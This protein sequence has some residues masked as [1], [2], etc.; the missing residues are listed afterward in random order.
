MNENEISAVVQNMLELMEPASLSPEQTSNVPKV[1]PTSMKRNKVRIEVELEKEDNL[2]NLTS[3]SI[4]PETGYVAVKSSTAP[5][6]D[7][8]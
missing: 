7:S 3:M 8:H 1:S 5:I 4:E 6:E 2:L